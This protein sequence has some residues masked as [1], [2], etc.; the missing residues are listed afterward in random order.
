MTDA[1]DASDAIRG[2]ADEFQAASISASHAVDPARAADIFHVEV[3]VVADSLDVLADALA[4]AGTAA[5]LAD[6][7]V[8]ALDAMATLPC[9]ADS[10]PDASRAVERA[11]ASAFPRPRQRL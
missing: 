3:E 1:I 4:D 5:P 11:S 10:D 8:G 6:P 7:L 2:A 9:I